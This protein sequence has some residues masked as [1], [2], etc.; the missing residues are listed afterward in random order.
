MWSGEQGGLTYLK[1]WKKENYFETGKPIPLTKKFFWENQENEKQYVFTN[2]WCPQ[3]YCCCTYIV[4]ILS[5][6]YSRNSSWNFSVCRQLRNYRSKASQL[7]QVNQPTNQPQ[8]VI[9]ITEEHKK[10]AL[11]CSLIKHRCY[12]AQNLREE[13]IG[14]ISSA[15]QINTPIENHKL[16]SVQRTEDSEKSAR[17][18]QI[19]WRLAEF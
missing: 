15:K 17:S 14:S 8:T 4:P 19:F 3:G 2:S 10:R 5:I 16:I 18:A 13:F 11:R 7:I 9:Y 1:K 12:S 6:K